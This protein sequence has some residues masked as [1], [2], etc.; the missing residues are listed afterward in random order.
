V[1]GPTGLFSGSSGAYRGRARCSRMTFCRDLRTWIECL[2]KLAQ[3]FKD[4]DAEGGAIWE[5]RIQY[6]KSLRDPAIIGI[7]QVDLS[8]VMLPNALPISTAK[9]CRIESGKSLLQEKDVVS[10]HL[11]ETSLKLSLRQFTQNSSN[12]WGYSP[13]ATCRDIFFAAAASFISLSYI[14][15]HEAQVSGIFGN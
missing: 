6:W 12:K 4:V 9:P 10:C 11:S 13:V 1:V 2:Y 7:L 3:V 5:K 8:D 14:L 15:R